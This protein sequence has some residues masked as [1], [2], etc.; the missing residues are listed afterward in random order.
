MQNDASYI[1]C[2]QSGKMILSREEYLSF[3][4]ADAERNHM[5]RPLKQWLSANDNYYIHKQLRTLRRVEYHRGQRG[6]LHRLLYL[7]NYLKLRRLILRTE[8]MMFPGTIGPG[9]QIMHPGFRRIDRF[10]TIGANCTI[11]P[12]VLFGRKHPTDTDSQITVGDNCYISTGVTI[13]GPV[14]IGD[15][16]T[17]AAGAVVI[18]DCPSNTVVGGVPARILKTK[19]M[20]L[21]SINK[22]GGVKRIYNLLLSAPY[23]IALKLLRLVNRPRFKTIGR[24]VTFD[25]ISSIFYYTHISIGDYVQIGP[26]ASMIASIAYIHIGNKVRFGP[27]VTIRGGDHRFDIPGKFMYD[28]KESDKLPENDADVFIEDDTWIGTNVTI[29]KGV[30]I[31]RGSIVA[32]G[33]VVTKSVPPYSIAAGVPAKIIGKRFKQPGQIEIHEKTLFADNPLPPEAYA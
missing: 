15:N 4:R 26:G 22:W 14:T 32:A 23:R 5:G 27:N 7:W 31:G 3:R 21:T 17:I 9:L 33:A 25:P 2:Q 18:S 29:L 6:L 13:L 20:K 19:D 1:F 11:L 30:T 16:V 24:A 10:V 8:I 28:Y 12:M